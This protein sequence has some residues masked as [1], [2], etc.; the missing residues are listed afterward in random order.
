MSQACEQLIL[1]WMT[2]I[3][4]IQKNIEK[5]D[6]RECTLVSRTNRCESLTCTVRVQSCSVRRKSFVWLE[7]FVS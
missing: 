7:V 5:I 4:L 2:N 6:E 1:G 3:E